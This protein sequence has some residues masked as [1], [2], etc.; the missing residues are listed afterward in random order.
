[1]NF[2]SLAGFLVLLGVIAAGIVMSITPKEYHLFMDLPALLLVIGGTI[3]V[4]AITVQI[5]RIGVLIKVFF[6]GLTKGKRVDYVTVIK[7]IM[8]SSEKYRKGEALPAIISQVDDHFLK[9]GLQLLSDN[10]IKGEELYDLLGDRAKNMYYHYNE[11]AIHFRNLGKFPPAFGLMGTVLGMIALL[12][13]LGG[14]DAMKMIGPA[15]GMCLVATF[16]GIVMA[17]VFILP[18]AETLSQSAKEIYLKNKIIAEG[19]RLIANKTNPIVVAEKLNTFLLPNDR[20][21]W[22]TMGNLKA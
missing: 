19:M 15:M 10:V 8:V 12:S 4:G 11:G 20:V 17:N 2:F 9:E 18:M 6:V 14:A 7:E 5:N 21:D 3:A 1:M 13:N 16:L 22:K